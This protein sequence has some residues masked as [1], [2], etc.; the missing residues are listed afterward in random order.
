MTRRSSRPRC[1]SCRPT[2]PRVPAYRRGTHRLRRSRRRWSR[3]R[4]RW[5]RIRRLGAIIG[6]VGT[7]VSAP[8]GILDRGQEGIVE[9]VNLVD[10]FLGCGCGLGF[11]IGTGVGLRPGNDG[12]RVL[13]VAIGKVFEGRLD[14]FQALGGLEIGRGARGIGEDGQDVVDAVDFVVGDISAKRI[15]LEEFL[16]AVDQD[17]AVVATSSR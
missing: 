4:R 12:V 14:V 6:G 10:G 3:T 2:R 7:A 5:R 11:L 8:A 9:G 1:R 16:E 15:D 17:E 13:G